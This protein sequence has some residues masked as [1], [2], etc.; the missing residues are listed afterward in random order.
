YAL[1]AAINFVIFLTKNMRARR[2][3]LYAKILDDLRWGR[4]TDQQLDILN[5]RV[6]K[7]ED[8]L[9]ARTND[10]HNLYKPVVVCTNKLRCAINSNIIFRIALSRTIPVFECLAIPCNRSRLIVEHLWNIDDNFTDRIPMKLL[11]YVGMPVMVTHKHP[12]LLGADIIANG[13][14]ATIIGT[15]PPL[16]EMP[17]IIYEAGNVVIHKLLRQPS[18]LLIKLLGVTTTLVEGF[19]EGVIG[20]PALK[21]RVS[22]KQI[23]NLAR[24]SITVTQFALVPAFACTTEKLQGQTCHDGVV[25]TPLD[26]RQSVPSQTLYVALSRSVSLDGLSLTQSI[27]RSYLGKFVPN[28]ETVNEMQ[29]LMNLVSVPPFASAEERISFDQ[30]KSTQHT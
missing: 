17:E 20:L 11:F 29:R 21:G 1:Y 26:N 7:P 19:P 22:L 23:P 16:D 5:S 24:S 2:D 4:L 3:P 6:H 25:V 9:S 18:L 27:S 15:Y 13:T 28:Q 8:L 12:D 30:W 10:T 14:I